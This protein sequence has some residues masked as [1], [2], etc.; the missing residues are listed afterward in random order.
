MRRVL[1]AAASHV[2]G[3]LRMGRHWM[4]AEDPEETQSTTDKCPRQSQRAQVK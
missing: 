2:Q 1:P 4:A 3:T